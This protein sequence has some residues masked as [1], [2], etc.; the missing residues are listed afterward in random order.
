MSETHPGMNFQTNLSRF[1]ILGYEVSQQE[2][3]MLFQSSSCFV[4]WLNFEFFEY[5]YLRPLKKRKT[6]KSFDEQNSNSDLVYKHRMPEG[7]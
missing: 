3:R 4:Y 5:F 6:T 2:P 7:C 1:V